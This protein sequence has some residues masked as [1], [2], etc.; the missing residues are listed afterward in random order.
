MPNFAEPQGF[1]RT[2]VRFSYNEWVFEGRARKVCGES[3]A[4][5]F[6]TKPENRNNT[7][8]RE[9]IRL[10][11]YF[12]VGQY[13]QK[14]DIVTSMLSPFFAHLSI[15]TAMC[16]VSCYSPWQCGQNCKEQFTPKVV[17]FRASDNWDRAEGSSGET[18]IG[19]LPIRFLSWSVP[20]PRE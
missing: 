12:L 6:H 20:L 7:L 1:R 17:W 4:Y 3:S 14:W 19:P 9:V 5:H 18:F 13:M 15:S 8:A 16:F 10:I 2:G 11:Y